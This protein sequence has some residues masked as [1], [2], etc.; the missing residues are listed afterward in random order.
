VQSRK[1]EWKDY[2][3]WA[4][5]VQ[6]RPPPGSVV[7][8]FDLAASVV[9][10]R[11]VIR[12]PLDM[13]PIHESTE[14]PW[15][16]ESDRDL[17]WKS[18]RS[19]RVIVHIEPQEKWTPWPEGDPETFSVAYRC[20]DAPVWQVD[21]LNKGAE[22]SF[23]CQ[24]SHWD[25]EKSRPS[26]VFF[27][28]DAKA[29]DWCEVVVLRND[30]AVVAEALESEETCGAQQRCC[31]MAPEDTKKNSIFKKN[32]KGPEGPKYPAKCVQQELALGKSTCKA[33]G[34]TKVDHERC[35]GS[36]MFTNIGTNFPL[37]SKHA[38]SV[39]D[40]CGQMERCCRWREPLWYHIE[41]ASG[42]LQ[43]KRKQ[44]G[45]ADG[46][47]TKIANLTK[48]VLAANDGIW[49]IRK[50]EESVAAAVAATCHGGLA[51]SMLM[52][53]PDFD[54]GYHACIRAPECPDLPSLD[55]RYDDLVL[56]GEVAD[57]EMCTAWPLYTRRETVRRTLATK[58]REA[59][60]R[61]LRQVRGE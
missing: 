9:G 40:G 20:G 17:Q 33:F 15:R 32:R 61:A 24:P 12:I 35:V 4:K 50:G 47:C 52:N 58:Q 54:D 56:K 57:N 14:Y 7:Q 39:G 31:T 11:K 36:G 6:E 25:R 34:G 1:P 23:F 13:I 42:G 30:H 48:N 5:E 59:D 49:R 8:P 26:C 16:K 43:H 18:I 2:R 29:N 45:V 21:V 10:I 19:W 28:V 55:P 51:K 37:F 38:P 46:P 41:R 22:E 44:Y 3:P 60:F 53:M 27:E